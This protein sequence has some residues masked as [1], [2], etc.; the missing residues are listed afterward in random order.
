MLQHLKPFN[1]KLIETRI[2]MVEMYAWMQRMVKVL[3]KVH[4]SVFKGQ[5]L[6]QDDY[7][8]MGPYERR[9]Q[10]IDQSTVHELNVIGKK[11][12]D[13]IKIFQSYIPDK[14]MKTNTENQDI[15]KAK[16]DIASMG[17]SLHEDKLIMDEQTKKQRNFDKKILDKVSSRKP[18]LDL[19]RQIQRDGNF[20]D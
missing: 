7:D 14:H 16:S 10:T 9:N 3:K 19:E 18:L 6:E 13:R 4:V 15:Q 17:Q 11:E 5:S 20:I 12:Y 1:N 2:Q 8:M